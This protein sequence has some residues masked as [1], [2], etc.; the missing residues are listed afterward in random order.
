MCHFIGLWLGSVMLKVLS[1][2]GSQTLT[3][4]LFL[5]VNKGNT[6]NDVWL[7]G[8]RCWLGSFVIFQAM[9]TS[10]AKEPYS[11]VIF[12]GGGGHLDPRMS[13]I[14]AFSGQT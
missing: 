2:W 13:V 4:L 14:G 10:I 12:R 5:P 8:R 7:A 6:K 3:F 1:G 9:R 11:F